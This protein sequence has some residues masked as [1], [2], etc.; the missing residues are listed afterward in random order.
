LLKYSSYKYLEPL[1]NWSESYKDTRTLF[2]TVS[3]EIS[4]NE[5]TISFLTT[6]F[7]VLKNRK[8]DNKA[9]I[10]ED[11]NW[12]NVSRETKVHLFQKS[13]FSDTK[14]LH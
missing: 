6:E 1:L 4:K 9:I 13:R 10:F 11:T 12:L 7:S 2:L 14:I 8:D 3:F 5:E